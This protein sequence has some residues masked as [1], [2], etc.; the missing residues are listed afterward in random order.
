M[1]VSW[2]R[3]KALVV[4]ILSMAWVALFA[5]PGIYWEIH[6]E[7]E[8]G[9][10]FER[11]TIWAD[12]FRMFLSVNPLLGIGPGNYHPFVFY[13]NTIWFGGTT[14]TT[15]HSNYVQMAAETGILGL[16]A[17]LWVIVGGLALG[18]RGT[19]RMPPD[20]RWLGIGGTAAL[21]GIAA[22]SVFGDY[23]FPSRGNNGLMTF[24]TTVYTW[25]IMGAVAAAASIKDPEK[26]EPEVLGP[27]R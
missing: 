11:F 17:F 4:G 14:Y 25:L 7:S 8:A 15:A 3:S 23:L 16:A 13:H 1:E 18:I 6:S 12:A 21:A 27:D 9:G 26:S 2:Y 22:A 19:K 5:Y 10:D 24:G 20:L